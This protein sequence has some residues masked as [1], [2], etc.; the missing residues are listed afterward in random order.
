MTQATGCKQCSSSTKDS[1]CWRTATKK[2]TNAEPPAAETAQVAAGAATPMDG[3]MTL[4]SRLTQEQNANLTRMEEVDLQNPR[5]ANDTSKKNQTNDTLIQRG[6]R[7]AQ[8][9][10]P[11][12][13]L[14]Q[15]RAALMIEGPES[16]KK[17]RVE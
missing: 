9:L 6:L 16:D 7:A 10:D 5:Q 14:G 13:H 4:I 12:I 2:P 17:P 3:M 15:A 1:C 8:A 11:M